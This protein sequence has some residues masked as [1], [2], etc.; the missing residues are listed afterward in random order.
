MTETALDDEKLKGE[1]LD[2][3]LVGGGPVVPHKIGTLSQD[4]RK[5]F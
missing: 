3:V 5:A 4:L 1:D 2:D